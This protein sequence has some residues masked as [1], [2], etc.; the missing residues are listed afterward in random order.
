MRIAQ[1]NG[2]A[3]T[4][5]PLWARRHA[6]AVFCFRQLRGKSR[7]TQT[8]KELLAKTKDSGSAVSGLEHLNFARYLAMRTLFNLDFTK[9]VVVCL[10]ALAATSAQAQSTITIG[11]T[12]VLSASD[13]DN[14]NQ[15]VAQEAPL[16]QSAT[17]NSLSFYVTHAA[18]RLRM[19]I[20]DATGP[21]EG[22]GRLMAQTSSLTPSVGWN[23]ADVVTP[24][25]LPPGNYWLTYL[26]SSNN[27]SFVKQNVSGNCEYHS[28]NYGPMPSSFSASPSN[29]TPTTWS[30]YATLT[31]S[32]TAV[33]GECG[34]ANGV[35]VSS[36]PTTGLC[37]AGT[38]SAVSGSGPWTWSC[39]GSNGGSTAYCEAPTTTAAEKPG[40]SAELFSNPYYTCVT[41]YYVATTGNDSNN[42]TSQGTPWRTL[43]HA[44]DSLAAG[45]AAAGSCINLAPGV[46]SEANTLDINQGG[47][48]A[49]TAGYIVWRCEIMPFSFANGALQGEGNGC[50]IRDTSASNYYVA[51]INGGVSYVMFDAI[52][53]DGNNFTA[54]AVCLDDENGGKGSIGAAT[55]HH[56]WVINSDIHGCG[57]SGI[58]WNNTEWLFVIHNVWHD[59]SATSGYDGSGLSFWEPVGL[60]TY[61]PTAQ[62]NAWCS[63]TTGLCYHMVVAY[64]VG[65][66]NYNSQ[67]GDSNT[68]GEGIVL[69][70][71]GWEQNACPGQG[72]CPYTG[73]ALVMGN[74][75]YDNGGAGIEAFSWKNT[76][77]AKA[78]IVNNTTYD[79]YWDTHNPG[80]WRGDFYL[81]DAYNITYM[82]NVAYTVTGSGVLVNNAPFLAAGARVKPTDTS[83]TNNLSYP[84]GLN[85]IQS[86]YSYPT[87]G[88]NHNL[89]GSNPGLSSLT[90]GST[91][92]NFVLQPGSPA[93][94]FGQAFDLW[95]QS[96]SI[97]AGAC[98][99]S[100]T[101]CP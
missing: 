36:A 89:D 43:Q 20:Y 23:T 91:A 19:G 79:N 52:E 80:T 42:G 69:D 74:I 59:N 82:N 7:E 24:V 64:N 85:N 56:I 86:G 30:F 101:T 94:G 4:F 72:V 68:D 28:F 49:T 18:G 33:N 10:L 1:P 81:S 75:M 50:V 55:S 70:D 8:K 15:L 58:Q 77:T 73:A 39:A 97:D 46:Y 17:I 47:N 88:A 48:A 51:M 2:G 12:S 34:P 9:F 95:P 13:G 53:F 35:S 5:L 90:P 6:R 32:S 14:G 54:G 22:P 57:Q 78:T 11:E 92:N 66:H 25:S 100:L 31:A 3:R 76:S 83:W 65:Y 62:D 38:A 99:S 84:G 44:S 29:C 87:T 16:S 67:S 98:P 41:N 61:T 93:I 63:K 27:L 37:T 21:G 26:P 45:G 96:G 71:W 40:P 60:A